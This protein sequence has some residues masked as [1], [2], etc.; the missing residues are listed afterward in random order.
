MPRTVA[1]EPA[2]Q[3]TVADRLRGARRRAFVGRAA[4]L[5]LFRL[6]LEA[7]EPPFSVLWIAGPGGV[8]K[9]TLLAALADESRAA[10]RT[11]VLVDLRAIEP[12]PVAFMAELERLAGPAADER[13]LLMLDTFELAGPLEAWLRETFLPGLPGG[14]LVVVAG[15][16]RPTGAW[17]ED[18]G[19][20]EL[21][22]VIALRN[23][24][25]DDARELLRRVGVAPELHG[26][27]IERTHCHPLALALMLDVLAQR[28]AGGDHTPPQLADAPDV[29]ARLVGCF[30]AGVPS[31]RHRLALE[32]AAHAHYTTAR[33]LRSAF[34]ESDGDELFAW[35][36]G[37]SF[38]DSAPYGLF[39]HDLARDV[40]D[41]DLR[42]RD[43]TAYGRVHAYVR[44]DVVD[45]IRNA[46][47][48]EHQSA[49]A[50]LMFLHRG[51]PAARAFW[52]WESLGRVYA[53][54]VRHGDHDTILAMVR[55]HEGA[56]SAAIAA[57]W[58][59]RR[60]DGFAA[61]RGDRE[62][63]VGF[64][65]QF[66]LHAGADLAHD[67]GAAA[68]WEHAQRHAPPLPGDQVVAARFAMDRDAYQAPSQSFNMITIRSTQDWLS[69]PRLAWYYL[70][71]ADPDA[72]APMMAY[73]GFERAPDADF[74]V[75]GRRYAVF[76]RDWRRESA[77]DWLDRMADRELGGDAP[78]PA[79]AAPEPLALSQS[80][81]A[82]A[83]RR[84]LR[85]LHNPAALTA[86]PLV[87]ARVVRDAEGADGAA[88]RA[89]IE[90]AID[91]LR[92]DPRDAKLVRALDRTYLRPASTQEAA[93]D[94]LG[95]PFSTY[96]GHLARG[97]D[98]VAERL[99]Q[100]ELYGPDPD[101]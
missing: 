24:D 66:V 29:I 53:E 16:D 69:R 50:D 42:W 61:F 79:S 86:N 70:T 18:P 44:A 2:S 36:R 46:H 45:R 34:G 40:I 64:L 71:F 5:E 99:W 41:A 11:P 8:G 43:S 92:A 83:V 47:G 73:I 10:G 9:T 48:R 31:P 54:P 30:V 62:D 74:E 98:R 39:P 12:S 90:H 20:R 95:L 72:I 1:Q 3:S 85:D 15:R 51:N 58:L 17:R 94:L 6:A 65:A 37:L 82:R 38:V 4:E 60:P 93:A 67:P 101:R 96:R 81:F 87:G 26:W 55:R 33:L 21:L 57:R 32:I 25:P 19:W 59:E 63:P 75:G 89:L 27:V 78:A 77:A 76:A 84:A 100:R 35:L 88:L 13:Q 49:L 56:E 23:L 97:L 52:D 14:A 22:R 28:R 80:E 91:E 7:Q 68:M